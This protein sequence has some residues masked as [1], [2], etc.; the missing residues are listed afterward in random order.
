MPWLRMWTA[1]RTMRK[2]CAASMVCKDILPWNTSALQAQRKATRM[3]M[4]EILSLWTSS[5]RGLQNYHVPQTLVRIATRR[6]LPTSR[7]GTNDLMLNVRRVQE[8]LLLHPLIMI[9]H[10]CLVEEKRRGIAFESE[11]IWLNEFKVWLCFS[12][13]RYSRWGIKARPLSLSLFD[14]WTFFTAQH[15]RMIIHVFAPRRLKR[16]VPTAW[17]RKRA[18]CRRIDVRASV[19]GLSFQSEND[20]NM[21]ND[22]TST[23]GNDVTS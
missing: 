18:K 3:R 17:K 10:D 6:I 11:R 20:E 7:R 4:V 19:I 2:T 13:V 16:W 23:F 9:R 15:S 22:V 1:P 5:W 12:I 8:R 21:Q 14:A